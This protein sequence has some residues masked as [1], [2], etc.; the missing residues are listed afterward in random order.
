MF[1]E[2]IEIFG[3]KTFVKN[4]KFVLSKGI[5][6]IVGPN[7]SGK[8]NIVDAIR[9]AFGENKLNLLRAGVSSDLIFSGSATKA[10]MNVASVK[11]I[12]NNEDRTLPIKTP[13]V[14]IERRIVRDKGTRYFVNG[15]ETGKE[16]VF[17]I[18]KKANIFGIN[19]AIVGQ[20]RIEEILLAKPEEKKNIID[21]V[22]G[23]LD[24]RKKKEEAE[25]NL[26]E[27]EENLLKVY[28]LFKVA[29]EEYEKVL[30][31][32]KKVHIYYALQ[33]DLKKAEEK[34]LNYRIEKVKE[35]LEMLNIGLEEKKKEEGSIVE[36]LLDLKKAYEDNYKEFTLKQKELEDL[37]EKK[38]SLILEKTK[39]LN[40]I[41]SY[42][43]FIDLKKNELT[44]LNLRKE[45]L[46][47]TKNYI[48]FD[49]KEI[50][51]NIEKLENEQNIVKAQ[52]TQSE[53]KLK[54]KLDA[55]I[56]LEKEFEEFKQLLSEKQSKRVKL[57]KLIA[58][59][60][61]EIELAKL[62]IEEIN[63]K[64]KLYE[65]LEEY[66]TLA[67]KSQLRDIESEISQKNEELI[68]IDKKHAV[69]GFQLKTLKKEIDA[70]RIP[71]FKEN[72]LGYYL[73]VDKNIFGLKDYFEGIIVNSIEEIKA[74]DGERFFLDTQF[75]IENT[76]IDNLI[77]ISNFFKE[78]NKFL[79]GIYLAKN[80]E[81]ALK[82]FRENF[83]KVYIREIITEDGYVVLSPFEV[84]KKRG[85]N[86]QIENE[87]KSLREESENIANSMN[88]LKEEILTLEKEKEEILTDIEKANETDRKKRE[89]TNLLSEI[90]NYKQTIEEK[91]EIVSKL[92][93][94]LEELMSKYISFDDEKL[95]SAR[96][97]VETL[98]DTISNLKLREKELELRLENA[99]RE[100]D[101]KR[102]RTTNI[103]RDLEEIE[104]EKQN[105]EKLINEKESALKGLIDKLNALELDI[106]HFSKELEEKKGSFTEIENLIKN[107]S[108]KIEEHTEMKESFRDILQRIEINIA[109]EETNLE[110]LINEAKEKGLRVYELDYEIDEE[111]LK[112]NILKLKKELETLTP[113]DFTSVEREEALKTSFEEKKSAYED[114]AT[115][116]KE[117][118]KYVKEIDT[119][120]KNTF[121]KTFE[122]LKKH[123]QNIFLSIFGSGEAD[124]EKIYDDNGEVKGV[125]MV[126][127]LPFKRKQPLNMLSGG[128]KSLVALAFL[129]AIF[130]VNPSPFYVLDEIDASYDDENVYKFGNLIE[131]F[132]KKSQFIIITHNKQTMEKGDILY[133]ITMEEDGISK[134]VSLKLV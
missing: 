3:F 64:L 61:K 82:V 13:R 48:L 36:K 38:E 54:E 74:K 129:F 91:T 92:K 86:L 104:K 31:E 102:R 127:R 45:K 57:E 120:I 25:K 15:E 28:S 42:N 49:T 103:D 14:I 111:A 80:L 100:I 79:Y 41:D 20:G 23:I 90:E 69:I 65:N 124:L 94:D 67:L 99:T 30:A 19:H 17:E 72:S 53:T 1:I 29:K 89:K 44:E 34:L 52:L 116:K 117:L 118:Q 110:N 101:E 66:D 24:L 112:I 21:G 46:E 43:N 75:N 7:G 98:R 6:C 60:E 126:V 26:L 115:S 2:S 9:F 37:K 55:L 59:F 93:T 85:L 133:G 123:F 16:N 88:V 71:S 10:P 84:E 73:K 106:L 51:K 105:I 32:A 11:I 107:I 128:E 47:K 8:S 96:K 108:A 4:T 97:L 121:D 77:P 39:L 131:K 130:E 62:K 132:S 22:S 76:S 114:V 40:L 33:S 50:E 58:S 109:R 56:P 119:K 125:E 95:S 5:T 81:S 68:D 27:A 122:D 70:F 87:Y 83:N 134:A 35:K 63:K 78:N 18:F 113:L 12:L